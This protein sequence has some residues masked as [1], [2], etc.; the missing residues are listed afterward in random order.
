MSPHGDHRISM[1]LPTKSVTLAAASYPGGIRCY[2]KL[3]GGEV[4]EASLELSDEALGKAM[5]DG[6]SNIVAATTGWTSSTLPF[7][8]H[9]QSSLCTIAWDA[10][11]QSVFYQDEAGKLCEQR[12]TEG[13]HWKLSKTFNAPKVTLGTNIASVASPR[14]RKAMLIYQHENGSIYYHTVSNDR[15]DVAKELLHTKVNGRTGIGATSWDDLED[16][17]V[18]VQ[19]KKH[20]IRQ[21]RKVSDGDWQ[22]TEGVVTSTHDINDITAVGWGPKDKREVRLY[23][24]DEPGNIIEY[25]SEDNNKKV[26]FARGDFQQAAVRNSDIIGFVRNVNAAPGFCVNLMWVDTNQAVQQCIYNGKDWLPP[27][28]I[29]YVDPLNMPGLWDKGPQFDDHDIATAVKNAASRKYVSEIRIRAD[30]GG[31][32]A[33]ALAYTDGDVTETHGRAGKEQPTVFALSRGED[34]TTVWYRTDQKGLAGLQFGTSQ[35]R[36]TQWFGSGLG[37]FGRLDSG[38]HALIG[39]AGAVDEDYSNKIVGIRPIWSHVQPRRAH[40]DVAGKV[41]SVEDVLSRVPA[42]SA[43][44]QQRAAGVQAAQSALEPAT[45]DAMAALADLT[46]SVEML[47]GFEH[48]KTGA[49]VRATERRN[50]FVDEQLAVCDED[51]KAVAARFK[52]VAER[53]AGLPSEAQKL[54]AE[55]DALQQKANHAELEDAIKTKIDEILKL[56]AKFQKELTSRTLQ[57]EDA[58][59]AA[60][61]SATR[62]AENRAAGGADQPSPA[63]TK[64]PQNPFG[65]ASAPTSTAHES[66]ETRD[67]R[68]QAEKDAGEL[69]YHVA[70]RDFRAAC[71]ARLDS[72]L[73]ELEGV[74]ARL[75]DALKVPA[76]AKA[77]E[78]VAALEAQLVTREKEIAELAAVLGELAP[79]CGQLAGKTGSKAFAKALL[80]IVEKV[81]AHAGLK[82]LCSKV[83]AH[84]LLA[85]AQRLAA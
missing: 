17:R 84:I 79:L 16:I 8:V 9:P 44:I 43:Q 27:A 7:K 33:L 25:K 70:H 47:H 62:Y 75:R 32:Y 56:K 39:F 5:R 67:W 35:G 10:H 19:S 71:I 60:N 59:T 34:I 29:A 64:G 12:L 48:A 6:N 23:V 14:D 28:K 13:K 61:K 11:S 50:R 76:V 37:A 31:I 22:V 4:R 82:G 15:W 68:E 21:Y 53:V 40:E 63:D 24:Q 72:D 54:R 46:E 45:K 2:T 18:Y 80:P 73:K 74:S 42:E 49:Q 38:G 51:A 3:I 81:D 69:A 52:A 83:E 85:A 58:T 1:S 20:N 78:E 26:P 66:D 65:A 57:V 41:A 30:N 77:F 55:I 36:T